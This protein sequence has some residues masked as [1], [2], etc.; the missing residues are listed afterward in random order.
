MA[1][2]ATTTP[3]ASTQ[4]EEFDPLEFWLRY[5]SQILLYTGMVVAALII[6]FV[7]WSV[8]TAT[9]EHSEQAL[10]AAKSPEDYRKVA[11]SYPRSAAGGDALLFLADAQRKEG[12][13]DDANATLRGFI[14]KH[15]KHTLI[16]GAYTSLG[17]NLE[18]QAKL[19][20][21][22]TNYKKVTTTYPTS[23]SAPIA[24]IAQGR[25][26]QAQNKTE[27][28]R[29]AYETVMTQFPESPF[30]QEAMSLM[31]KLKK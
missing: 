15:P 9:R 22:L 23:F 21:A 20:D 5:R 2:P 17:A 7:Y 12:K 16:A 6:Y 14:E 26:L 10:V 11:E 27:E 18:A 4:P 25:V 30:R 28:A 8:Q 24:Y 1:S 13:L 3:P 29:H 19:D 31:G